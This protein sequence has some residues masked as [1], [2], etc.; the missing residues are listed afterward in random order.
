MFAPRLAVTTELHFCADSTQETSEEVETTSQ[1]SLLLWCPVNRGPKLRHNKQTGAFI[2]KLAECS[3]KCCE[4]LISFNVTFFLRR[5]D[6][7]SLIFIFILMI[8]ATPGS[9]WFLNKQLL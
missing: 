2:L 9:K 5:M 3:I 6:V 1:L 4:S 8:F 7:H